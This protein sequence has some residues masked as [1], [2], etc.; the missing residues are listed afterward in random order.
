MRV[1]KG[2]GLRAAYRSTVP[3]IVSGSTNAAAIKKGKR[4]DQRSRKA[5]EIASTLVVGIDIFR[6]ALDYLDRAR[7]L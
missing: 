1:K 7:P 3:T 2:A 5:V 6:L 4:V